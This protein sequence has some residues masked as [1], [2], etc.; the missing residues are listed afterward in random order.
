[1]LQKVLGDHQQEIVKVQASYERWLETADMV[2][3]GCVTGVFITL[4]ANCF[5][6]ALNATQSFHRTALNG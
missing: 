1:M 5:Y 3:D 4:H 6:M 2:R